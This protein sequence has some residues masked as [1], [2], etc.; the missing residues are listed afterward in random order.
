MVGEV[1]KASDKKMVM[2]PKIV[3]VFLSSLTGFT[4]LFVWMV[5]MKFD[6]IKIKLKIIEMEK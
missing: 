6:L 4:A 2:G 1:V 3:L 5:K